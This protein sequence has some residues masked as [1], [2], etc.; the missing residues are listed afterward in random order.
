MTTTTGRP[1][2]SMRAKGERHT[3]SESIRNTGRTDP[4]DRIPIKSRSE[5]ARKRFG[6]S[7]SKRNW[8]LDR[9]IARWPCHGLQ[10]RAQIIG[11]A[12]AN[13]PPHMGGGPGLRMRSRSWS[14]STLPRLLHGRETRP[15]VACSPGPPKFA[16]PRSIY[17]A[18]GW[19]V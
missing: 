11:T 6:V 10:S 19:L 15:A 9:F 13:L 1:T 3:Q 18:S 5:A 14:W 12:R 2:M 16:R 17:A 4:L 8:L 7:R